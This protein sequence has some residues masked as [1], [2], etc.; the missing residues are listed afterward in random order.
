LRYRALRLSLENVIVMRM[1]AMKTEYPSAV[2]RW[3]AAVLIGSPLVVIGGGILL[4]EKSAE[5]GWI[6]IGI[7]LFLAVLMAALSIPCRYTLDEHSLTIRCGLLREVIPLARIRSVEKSA[8]L[9][10]A[11]ALSLRRVKI[12][13]DHGWR[14]ISPKD[15]DGFI[16]AIRDRLEK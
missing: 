12:V 10:S 11:P 6:Q 16:E 2:D 1:S 4:L 7:G 9:W 8:S 14:L 13:M 3:I 15:R 5:G